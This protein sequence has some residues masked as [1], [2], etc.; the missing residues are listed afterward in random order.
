M[1]A[2]AASALGQEVGKLFESAVL[3]SVRDEVEERSYSIRPARLRNGTGNQY[4]IDAVIFDSND[5]P[6]IIIDPKYIRYT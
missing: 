4:Q 2:R 6:I 3:E 1:V 5:Q